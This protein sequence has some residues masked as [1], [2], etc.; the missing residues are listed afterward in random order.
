M[1]APTAS[2]AA[3]ELQHRFR[4]EQVHRHLVPRCVAGELDRRVRDSFKG[5]EAILEDL[6]EPLRGSAFQHLVEHIRISSS[7]R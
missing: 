2:Q 7:A 4:D 3:A 6:E 1:A 5:R